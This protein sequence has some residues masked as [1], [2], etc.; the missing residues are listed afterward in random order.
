MASDL[1]A[2]IHRHRT[3]EQ[4]VR[5][6]LTQDPPVDVADVVTQDEFTHDVIFV[7]P[8]RRVVVYDAT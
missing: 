5:H 7:L 3:L 2:V 6:W 1:E 4:A 8:D